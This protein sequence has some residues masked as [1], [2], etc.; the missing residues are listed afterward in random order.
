MADDQLK[1]AV[2]AVANHLVV[3]ALNRTADDGSPGREDYPDIGEHDWQD[4]VTRAQQ[5][6]QR[7]APDPGYYQAAYGFLAHRAEGVKA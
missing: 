2:D 1:S 7:L 3:A 4:V 6:A 5:I